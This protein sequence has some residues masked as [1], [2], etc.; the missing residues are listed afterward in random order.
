MGAV[1]LSRV[2]DHDTVESRTAY[3][4]ERLWPRGLR[5]ADIVMT[6]WLKDVAPSAELRTWFGHVPERWEEFRR[7]YTVELDARP[8]AWQPLLDAAR[9]GDVTL[10]Y[11]SRDQQHNNAVVL[12]EYLSHKLEAQRTRS[13]S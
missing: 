5:R 7:R 4:V 2:Y 1:L 11:S 12:R 13:G 9:V 6:G 10:L 3:L 8:Q